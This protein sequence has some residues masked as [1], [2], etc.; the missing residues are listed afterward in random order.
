MREIPNKTNHMKLIEQLHGEPLEIIL[1]KKY[2]LEEK[3][4]DTIAKEMMLAT[5][6][7]FKWLDLANIKTR[8][9]PWNKGM[10][11]EVE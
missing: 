7:V 10:K 3:T 11:K 5:G 2:V 1:H 4:I 6:T 8:K 9:I